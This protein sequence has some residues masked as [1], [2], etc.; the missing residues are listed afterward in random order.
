MLHV[1]YLGV[2]YVS[3]FALMLQLFYPDVAYVFTHMLQ[4]F[5]LDVAYVLQWL[6][7]CFPCVSDVCCKCFNCFRGM[8]QVF[9]LFQT[10]VANVSSR[11]RKSESSVA[12]VADCSGPHLQQPQNMRVGVEEARVA[13]MGNRAGAYRDGSG[14]GTQ[15]G[16]GTW[17]GVGP[18]VKQACGAGVRTLAVRALAF[19]L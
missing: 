2:A 18:H 14:R 12:D 5:H 4:V 3:G 6:H 8:L 11:C 13:G 9:Q 7:T 1:F 17:S 19:P 16:D 10:Y 15:S